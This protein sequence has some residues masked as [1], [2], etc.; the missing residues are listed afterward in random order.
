[1]V[2]LSLIKISVTIVLAVVGWLV[3]HYFTTKRDIS[4]KRRS[5]VIEHLI[6]SY[7]ILTNDIA[8]REPT[9]ESNLKLENIL[10]DIQLF[11]SLEQINMSKELAT[12]VASGGFFELSPL[13]ASLR[14]DLRNELNLTK[15]D[16][17]VKWLRFNEK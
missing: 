12:K 6:E 9:N 5:L 2:D 13:I 7:R 10:S 8:Q 1:M 16:G 17:N 11:G 15:V 14:N 3:A 4:N